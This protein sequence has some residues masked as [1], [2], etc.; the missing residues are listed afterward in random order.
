[1]RYLILFFPF[2]LFTGCGIKGPL[3]LP[4]DP[5]DSYLSRVQ[6]S[7]NEMTGQDTVG[8]APAEVQDITIEE[9]PE[10]QKTPAAETDTPDQ[11]EKK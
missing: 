9:L 5:N 3:Y 6:S 1:M 8:Q 11:N 2:L 10:G 7:I 4:P